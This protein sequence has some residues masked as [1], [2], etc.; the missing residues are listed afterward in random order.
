MWVLP[1]SIASRYAAES[2]CSTKDSALDL[3]TLESKAERL[4]TLSG[5]RPQP[6]SYYG[7][8]KT[9]PWMRRLFGAAIWNDSQS[10]RFAA[11][12][13]A[14]LGGSPVSR[15]PSRGKGKAP[16]TTAGYGPQS[17]ESFT[18]WFLGSFFWKTSAA[19]S[20]RAASKPRS[21][22]W[23]TSGS[24]RS[25]ECYRREELGRAIG[26]SASSYW[27]TA[28][29][30]GNG[31]RK[32]ASEKSGN[33]LGTAAQEFWPTAVAT[34]G[35]TQVP[36][37]KRGINLR[38]ISQGW[39]TP[40][41][42]DGEKGGP[43]MQFGGGGVPLP[44]QTAQWMTPMVPNGGRKVSPEVVATKGKTESG[45]RTVGLESQAAHWATPTASDNSNRTTQPAPTHGNGHGM[46]LAG[47]ACRF[48]LPALG[49]AIGEPSSPTIRTSRPRLNPMF[50]CWLMG[51]P[52]WWTH[53][54]PISCG[55][56]EM[57]SWRL[58][59]RALLSA[60]LGEPGC[61]DNQRAA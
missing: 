55:R 38:T 53:P 16:K 59:Q 39:S 27:P 15:I 51:F 3:N 20:R 30:C 24:M 13:I 49:A 32:G 44:A 17:P 8:W 26:A 34:D 42:S 35:G 2:G 11:W 25:G 10:D 19:S 14:S 48:S 37:G 29:V 18:T 43:N 9:K 41:A 6:K 21:P 54:E 33:G 22:I 45:K 31:N 47:Q 12:W 4:P 46:V 61:S 52:I 60:L 56:R 1:S 40:R 58:K 5:K 50:V 23:P 28:T 57:A 36:D 7:A